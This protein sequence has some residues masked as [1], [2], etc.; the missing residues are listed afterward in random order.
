M[1]TTTTTQMALSS[2][3]PDARSFRSGSN[4]FKLRVNPETLERITEIQ[5]YFRSLQR[6]SSMELVV[7][8]SVAAFYDD[9]LDEGVVPPL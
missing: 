6:P 4:Q 8:E 5:K 2:S 7:A 9:L 3:Y 1:K